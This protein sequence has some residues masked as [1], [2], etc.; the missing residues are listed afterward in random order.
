[1][2]KEDSGWVICQMSKMK[3]QMSNVIRL[4]QVSD[5]L[6]GKEESGWVRVKRLN[7]EEEV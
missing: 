4:N 7:S 3:F 1:M 6:V 2:D 5:R